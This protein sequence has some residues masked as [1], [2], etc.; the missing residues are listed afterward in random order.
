MDLNRLSLFS[1]IS[2]RM[3][4]LGERQKIL[5]ENI[6]NVDTPRFEARDL[7]PF[8]VKAAGLSAGRRMALTQSDPAHA[9]GL[10]G[11][12]AHGTVKTKPTETTIS[13]NTVSMEGELMKSAETAMDYQLVTNLYRKQLGMIRAVL[14]RGP[15]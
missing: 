8:D 6:A 5:A 13:G 4:W 7:K 12:G 1:F 11:G 9:G 14:S 15:S 3:S 2:Q 10:R